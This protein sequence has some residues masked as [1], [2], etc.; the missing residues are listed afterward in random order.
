MVAISAISFFFGIQ[1]KTLQDLFSNSVARDTK[2]DR[3]AW[4]PSNS[5]AR[6]AKSAHNARDQ[7]RMRDREERRKRKKKAP[8]PFSDEN[9]DDFEPLPW[10]L[11]QPTPVRNKTSEEFMADYIAAKRKHNIPL[12]WEEKEKYAEKKVSLPLPI[13][14]LNFPKSA[15]L[16][17][18]AY[19]SCGGLTTFHTSTQN[20][21]IAI[22]MLEN[23]LHGTPPINGCDTKRP[24]V[25]SRYGEEVPVD[26]ISDIGL[27]GPPCYYASVHDGGLENI[28]KHYPNATILLVIRDAKSWYNSMKGW[29]SI[30]VRLK[31]FCGFDGKLHD[32][33]N[34]EYWR[35]MYDS[36]P[37]RREEE[38][39]VNFYHSHTQKIREFA[40]SHLSMTYVE[41]E[42]EN[43]D[44]GTILQ[45]YTK[46]SP[47]CVMN[48]HPGPFW[49]KKHN[50][51]SKCH[52]IGQ[53]P[54]ELKNDQPLKDEDDE[55]DNSD[56]ENA[57]SGDGSDDE[58]E[59][60]IEGE[61]GE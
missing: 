25:G 4:D 44:I 28:A 19:F 5:V 56:N 40:M 41:V 9:Y 8:L 12:P 13:I 57:D 36:L 54:A 16:T 42:L 39:W 21:R 60:D 3:D 58:V 7:D 24:R 10:T 61:N 2:S 17:M 29:G 51:T 26:F 35:N 38:Y 47:E 55:G 18:S 1:L 45:K 46:V 52:P 50:T 22:C 49:V 31:K 53:N 6:D 59:D 48:C 23:H 32:G 15:T 34:M 37:K 33:E 11:P 43:K 27:Q 30:L 20:G 14:A